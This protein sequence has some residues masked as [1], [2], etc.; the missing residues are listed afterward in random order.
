MAVELLQ[1]EPQPSNYEQWTRFYLEIADAKISVGNHVC[2]EQ[3]YEQVIKSLILVYLRSKNLGLILIKIHLVLDRF[4]ESII[5]AFSFLE[6]CIVWSSFIC[7]YH[8]KEIMQYVG[9]KFSVYFL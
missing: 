4:S 8:L 9:S 7:K 2:H 3:T 1:L 5:K 6:H